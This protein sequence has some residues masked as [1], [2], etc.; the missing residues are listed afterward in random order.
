MAGNGITVSCSRETLT[1]GRLLISQGMSAILSEMRMMETSTSP[2]LV[3]VQR[4]K[5]SR[6][7][8][9]KHYLL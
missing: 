5:N 1:R 2:V 3:V 7:T 4:R 8:N 9:R 6:R